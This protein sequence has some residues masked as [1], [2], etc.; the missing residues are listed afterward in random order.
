M[1]HSMKIRKKQKAN[2]RQPLS[3]ADLRFKIYT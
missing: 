2:C 3:K 1:C